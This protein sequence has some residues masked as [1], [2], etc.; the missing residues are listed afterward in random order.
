MVDEKIY[1]LSETDSNKLYLTNY[2]VKKII[3]RLKQNL[4]KILVQQIYNTN[5][6]IVS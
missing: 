4:Q 3:S 6:V 2:E 5:K 1:K